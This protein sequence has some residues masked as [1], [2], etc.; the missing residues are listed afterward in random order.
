MGLSAQRA[1]GCVF[2]DLDIEML[3][4]AIFLFFRD[5]S[6]SGFASS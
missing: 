6:Y 2:G 5:V 1:A 3:L 4:G